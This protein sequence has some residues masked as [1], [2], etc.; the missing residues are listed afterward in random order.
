MSTNDDITAPGTKA[1]RLCGADKPLVDFPPDGRRR[2][3]RQS[4]CREC[5]NAGQRAWRLANPERVRARDAADYQRHRES[6]RAG[7]A[8]WYAAHTSERRAY[9][10]A[11]RAANID[12]LRAESAAWRAANPDI[13]RESEARRRA[14]EREAPVVENVRRAVVWERDSGRC[15]LC[16][17][18]A[19]PHNWHLEHIVPLACGGEH[20][21]RNVAVSHPTCNFRKGV[22]GPAQMRLIG[23]V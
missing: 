10:A 18:K 9:N 4:S 20:S 12:R 5:C 2:D 15:H 14:R 6:K 21:Y 17:K 1:C 22:S 16:G 19:D 3:G 23:D 8:V 13:Q 11:W 7:Q